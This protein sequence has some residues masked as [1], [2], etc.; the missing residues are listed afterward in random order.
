MVDI[1]SFE[2]LFFNAKLDYIKLCMMC[3]SPLKIVL[4][5][6]LVFHAMAGVAQQDV[7]R[8]EMEVQHIIDRYQAVGLST[9]VVKSGKIVHKQHYGYQDLKTNTRLNDSSLFRI[10]SISK[11]F[12][13]TS[14]MQLV[15][16]KKLDLDG[17]VSQLIG[18]EVRNPSFPDIPITI[19]ML[20]SHTSSIN[21]KNGYFDFDVINPSKNP[22]WKESYNSYAPG[23]GY[24]YC[25]L[26]F[27]MIGAIIER[28]SGERFDGYVNRH[29]L[30]PLGLYGG[31]CVDSL[32]YSKFATLYEFDK[33]EMIPQPAAYNPRRNEIANY[34]MGYSTPIFSPTGGMKISTLDLARY[35]MMH[36]NY[37]MS[38]NSRIISEENAKIMQTKVSDTE[39]YGLALWQTTDLVSGV[40]L[41]GHTG[42]AY[43]LY[44]AMFF[45]PEQK[46]GFVVITNGCNQSENEG[47]NL[48]LKEVVNSL[49]HSFIE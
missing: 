23:K 44:S 24:Q 5:V 2:P 20:L 33:G 41:V 11:S 21:D 8:A 31:Y 48:L 49:Y 13:A 39:S 18:F 12:S 32:D 14:V 36:M 6:G 25:N 1:A 9:I 27:N 42:S 28:V 4:L 26:N 34:Q 38:N 45:D 10:A 16:A 29:I 15:E 17:D 30:T 37:G 46:Y 3:H 43:G 7:R 19:K 35:M 22:K 47:Y 40:K